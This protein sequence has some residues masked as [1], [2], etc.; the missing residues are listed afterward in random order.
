MYHTRVHPPSG[1]GGADR[2]RQIR[3]VL[4][5]ILWLNAIVA[6]AKGAYAWWS[7]S[8]A[9]G[10]DALHSVLDASANVIGL[11]ALWLADRPA[12][13]GHP[14]GHR[15]FEIVA[16]AAIGV[17]MAAG[18]LQFG[19][20]AARALA[21]GR[22][23]APAPPLGFAV[24]GGTWAVNLFVAAYEA[25]RGRALGSPLLVADA[26]HTASDVLVTAAVMASLVASRFGIQ[27]ADAAVALAVL[28]A[29]AYVAWRIV[30][31][32]LAVL[33]DAAAVDPDEVRAAAASVPGVVDCH[34][35]RSRGPEHHVHLDLHVRLHGDLS[36]RRAHAI[37][38]DLEDA[39]RA[40]I[41]AV[42]D[43]TIHM[44]PDDDEPEAL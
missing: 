1:V 38:H 5:I 3:R 31:R 22:P 29:V 24:V 21:G 23:V 18:V 25:R 4:W 9:V 15:R 17:V 2:A 13:A 10:T 36:L 20:T 39:I 16:A 26:G 7:G 11:V 32:N 44:E 42:A 27:W 35:I 12:D 37:A 19:W 33:V 30:T 8:L 6:A 14:Y 28:G 43:V 41:P 40:R 34:R